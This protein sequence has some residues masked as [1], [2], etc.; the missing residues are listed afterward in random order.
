ME[1]E[2]KIPNNKRNI[3]CATISKYVVL[4]A[5]NYFPTNATIV[6]NLSSYP[7]I[8]YVHKYKYNKDQCTYL[9]FRHAKIYA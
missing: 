5:L 6:M 4:E 1:V 8:L 2:T 3:I 9:V 7:L